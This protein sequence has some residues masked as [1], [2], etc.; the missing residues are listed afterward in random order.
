MQRDA[1]Y[2]CCGNNNK[3]SFVFWRCDDKAGMR[4]ILLKIYVKKERGNLHA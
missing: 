1:K 3:K 2:L 4:K